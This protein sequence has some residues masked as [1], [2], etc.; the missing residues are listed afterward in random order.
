MREAGGGDLLVG[1]M[2][3]SA[4]LRKTGKAEKAA[5]PAKQ[6]D[7]AAKPEAGKQ[8]TGQEVPVKHGT[9][10]FKAVVVRDAGG[11]LTARHRFQGKDCDHE[12]DV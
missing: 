6:E 8:V 7:E 4:E 5:R 3:R 10:T 11:Q 2:L 9:R 1:K 12:L